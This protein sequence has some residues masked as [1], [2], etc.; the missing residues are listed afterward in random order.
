MQ[1]FKQLVVQPAGCL[2]DHVVR[3]HIQVNQ[4]TAKLRLQSQQANY[5]QDDITEIEQQVLA[6]I[7][8]QNDMKNHIGIFISFLK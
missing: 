1:Q 4:V 6:H 3:G 7:F 8:G 2:P 5:F